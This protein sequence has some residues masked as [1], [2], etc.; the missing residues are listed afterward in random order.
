[1]PAVQGAAR[2]AFRPERG[3][4][5]AGAA[6]RRLDGLVME[7]LGM[8]VIFAAFLYALYRGLRKMG[9]L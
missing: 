2:E 3:R 4:L 1:M 6:L 7:M 8:L 9:D 5:L